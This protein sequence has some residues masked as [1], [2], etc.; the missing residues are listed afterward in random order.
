MC[1]CSELAHR[2]SGSSWPGR[3]RESVSTGAAEVGEPN[4]EQCTGRRAFP[5]R[6]AGRYGVSDSGHGHGQL[7]SEAVLLTCI[8]PVC[9]T[10][11]CSRPSGELSAAGTRR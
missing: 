4:P 7:G 5:T 3:V 10:S 8:S 1:S 6:S 2:T 11:T 9:T